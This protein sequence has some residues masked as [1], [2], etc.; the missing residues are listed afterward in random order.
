MP[1][2]SNIIR[3]A[4]RTK[5]DTLKCLTF[6]RENERYLRLFSQCNCEIY[7]IPKEGHSGWKKTVSS[8]PDNTFVF[9]NEDGFVHSRPFFDCIIANDRLQ[10][11]DIALSISTSLHLPIITV[12]HVSRKTLQK[13]PAAST[14]TVTSPLEARVGDINICLSEDI[15]KSWNTNS[16]GISI[17]IP[18]YI[19]KEAFEINGHKE[20]VVVDNNV[21]EQIMGNLT[22]KLS[23]FNLTPRFPEQYLEN[24][25]K[26]KVY[27]NTWNNIDIKTLEAMA[28]ECIT[29][30]PRTPE[31]EDIIEHGKN[32]LLFSDISELPEMIRA[33]E[34][35]SY[36]KILNKAIETVK[37]KSID[38]ESFVKK[39]NQV[40]AYISETFFL[41]N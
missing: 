22:A 12:D 37:E 20:G 14:V 23:E 2:I 19:D 7:I 5:N 33:S 25:N 6:C 15:K 18:P 1:T 24:K 16:Q 39:W 32:G 36:D 13:L 17:A 27:I 38:Q 10:E 41:R 29:I 35:G 3:S 31:T 26:N 30:S 28:A 40:L 11:F 9:N 34:S 21:P 4:T 8:L